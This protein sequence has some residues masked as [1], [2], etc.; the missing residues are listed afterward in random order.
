MNIGGWHASCWK[1]VGQI[2]GLVCFHYLFPKFNSHKFPLCVA[3]TV[4]FL[5]AKLSL[6]Y[7]STMYRPNWSLSGKSS[8]CILDLTHDTCSLFI[9]KLSSRWSPT[10]CCPKWSPRQ[11]STRGHLNWSCPRCASSVSGPHLV[12][13]HVRFHMT[14]N[15]IKGRWMITEHCKNSMGRFYQLGT[16][17]H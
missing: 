13:F 15:Y 10:D 16:R 11:F 3:R 1:C 12:K 4:N 2:N 17:G 14:Y 9:V 5:S 7:L 6:R 8:V